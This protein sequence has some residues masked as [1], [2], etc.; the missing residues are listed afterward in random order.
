MVVSME[1]WRGK[2]AIVTGASVGIGESIV[3]KLVEEGLQVVGL[4]R[5]SEKVEEHAKKLTGKKG[6]LHAFKADVSKEEDILKAF[7]WV[8]ENLGP[9]HILIN[10]A[11]IVQ[12]TNLVEGDTE[13]WQKIF[14]TNVI[15]LSVATRE[16][17]KI[18]KEN[19][20]DGHIV[21]INS[22]VGHKV[23]YHA[24]SNVYP[25]S[26]YAVTALTETLR[27]EFNHLGLKIKITSVS[28]G[29][30]ATELRQTNNFVMDENMKKAAA[31]RPQLKSEDVAEA[32]LYVLATPPHVQVHELT[33]KPVG[34]AL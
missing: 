20:I 34:E 16:A 9:V 29:V 3:E 22:I 32:V 23:A 13:K 18:M 31:T 21:H 11:G 2:V 19:K 15:G 24:F 12:Q 25:A 26:K 6:K 1:R 33:I 27:Q 4:A 14:D 8:T 7:K 17:V 5:R 10:N 30:V 28:P